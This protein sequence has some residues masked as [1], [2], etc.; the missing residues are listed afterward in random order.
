MSAGCANFIRL[1]FYQAT[2]VYS[3]KLIIYSFMNP[4]EHLDLKFQLKWLQESHVDS[5]FHMAGGWGPHIHLLWHE[6]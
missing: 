4:E 1:F 2:H 3:F 6:A 5:C